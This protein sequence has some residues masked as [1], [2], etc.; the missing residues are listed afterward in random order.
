MPQH[1][2]LALLLDAQVQ[3]DDLLSKTATIDLDRLMS[4]TDLQ[5]IFERR[6]EILGESLRRLQRVHPAVF[7][8]IE[9]AD[10]AIA[11]RNFIA[12]GYDSVDHRVLWDTA[13][14]DLPRMGRSI[15]VVIEALRRQ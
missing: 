8:Q 5:A 14:E 2:P 7:V 11:M 10:E 4:S 3:I 6:F 15:A 1:E 9:G 13:V 12:H